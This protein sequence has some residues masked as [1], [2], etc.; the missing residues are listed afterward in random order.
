MGLPLSMQYG[1]YIDFF[2]SVDICISIN[3]YVT[4]TTIYQFQYDIAKDEDVYDAV[5][6]QEARA[7][8]IEKA[9]DIYNETH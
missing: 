4:D 7:K 1:V 6:R 2:D 8:A 3:G 5:T 9:N